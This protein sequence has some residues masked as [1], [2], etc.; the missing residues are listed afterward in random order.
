MESERIFGRTLTTVEKRNQKIIHR[1]AGTIGQI[2]GT[3]Y[4]GFIVYVEAE[5]KVLQL[6]FKNVEQYSILEE[7]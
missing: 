3:T 4:G 1:K 5:G 7:V 6:P 2:K